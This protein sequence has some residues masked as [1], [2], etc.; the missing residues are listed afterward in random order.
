MIKPKIA[1]F[2]VETQKQ[3]IREMNDS[4]YAQYLI[5]IAA[6][7]ARITEQQAEAPTE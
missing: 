2:D 5:D 3:T 7:E 6:D 4:E 1:I